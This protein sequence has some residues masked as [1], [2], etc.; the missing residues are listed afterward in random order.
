MIL[1]KKG[2]GEK[3]VQGLNESEFKCKCGNDFCTMTPISRELIKC[4][5]MLRSTLG[6]PIKINSGYRCPAH[7]EQIGGSKLSR[8]MVGEALDLDLK[9]FD[10]LIKEEIDHLIMISGFK[11][12]K[13]YTSWVHVDIGVRN[14]NS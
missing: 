7:N 9:A 14:F 1:Y 4:Y 2:C 13:F 11:Y 3:I 8:H 5:G 12:Y 10:H 6:K